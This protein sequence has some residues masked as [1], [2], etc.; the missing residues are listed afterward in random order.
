MAE[1]A[2]D[3]QS[4]IA[5]QAAEGVYR[6]SVNRTKKEKQQCNVDWQA[7]F[8]RNRKSCEPSVKARAVFYAERR[9]SDE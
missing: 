9:V 7:Y 6:S 5:E 3:H 8:E 2:E 1:I 4:I